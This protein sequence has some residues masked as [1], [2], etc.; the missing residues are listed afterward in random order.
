LNDELRA[1][2]ADLHDLGAVRFSRPPTVWRARRRLRAVLQNTAVDTIVAHGAWPYALV[3]PV[4]R[5]LTRV[6][7]AHD[8]ATGE[9]WTEQ[10]VAQHPP[11]VA[12]CNSRFTER[13]IAAWLPGVR[14]VVLYAPVAGAAA[15]EAASDGVRDDVRAE[16]GAAPDATVI[17]IASRFERWKGHLELLE[18]ASGLNG[19]WTMWIAGA[20]QR[21]DE[22]EYARDLAARIAH[23]GL[24]GRVRLLG[25]RRDVPRLLRGADV[26]CQ[27]NTAPEPF[28]IVF[29]EALAAGVP[30]VATA[31]GGALEIVTADCGLLVPPGDVSSL[32]AALQDLVLDPERRRALGAAGPARAAVLC[33][34]ERQLAALD[35]L[36]AST[37]AP[38]AR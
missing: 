16:L 5:D 17:L 34:P 11:A 27:P 12:L 23:P 28:G 33:D 18:A 8:A 9:H 32:R 14:R 3:A 25:H 29:V 13:A 30:V 38:A 22:Q 7:W 21:G 6:L 24:I 15:G 35:S 1:A 26:L 4:S 2:G 10:A 19:N 20:P 31:A 36:F 37:V